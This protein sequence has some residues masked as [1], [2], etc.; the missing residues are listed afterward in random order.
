[1]LSTTTTK[2]NFKRLSLPTKKI[3]KP[4]G[5]TRTLGIPS[6]SW[7][8]YQHGLERILQVWLHPYSHPYQHGFLSSRGTDSAWR[9]I[10]REV[11]KSSDIYE[12]DLKKFFDSI[13]LDYLRRILLC[14][15]IPA[16]LVH[17]LIS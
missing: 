2:T 16:N 7:R 6:L 11:L 14:L 12:F 3:P 1:M 4:D 10:H 8:L 17:H 5:G 13:N 9:Q 15:Q